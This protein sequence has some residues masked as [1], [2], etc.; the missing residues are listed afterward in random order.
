MRWRLGESLRGMLLNA[1]GWWLVG[2]I[3][4]A[5]GWALI[6]VGVALTIGLIAVRSFPTFLLV[7]A[8]REKARLALERAEAIRPC[9]E[10]RQRRLRDG[11]V[12]HHRVDV[13]FPCAGPAGS[14]GRT[15]TAADEGG[16]H[17]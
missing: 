8:A 4:Q 1:Y 17:R 7:G 9:R 3:A 13:E 16:G 10:C 15:S 5:A 2:T 12:L 11:L 6:V 14:A